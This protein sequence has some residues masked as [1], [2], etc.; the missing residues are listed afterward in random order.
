MLAGRLIFFLH[1]TKI[2]RAFES[3]AEFATMTRHGIRT[4]VVSF[5]VLFGLFSFFSF[6]LSP[7]IWE[8]KVQV[9]RTKPQDTSFPY[10]LCRGMKTEVSRTQHMRHSHGV[11]LPL[12]NHWSRTILDSLIL[13]AQPSGQED[14][15]PLIVFP[16]RCY[17]LYP[18]LHQLLSRHG[19]INLVQH[20]AV[21]CLSI[22]FGR[23][24]IFV[25]AL[26]TYVK[27]TFGIPLV[28]SC[29]P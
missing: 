4:R 10:L 19:P 1:A 6:R 2:M 15:K 27:N 14:L 26:A 22:N 20:V 17:N 29:F 28:S 16:C 18:C 5:I 23:F 21:S 24:E 11:V 13:L 12:M 3:A 9:L 7:W 25:G 8:V